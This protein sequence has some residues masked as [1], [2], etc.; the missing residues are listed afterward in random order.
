MWIKSM[1][2]KRG[3]AFEECSHPD[4][5]TAQQLASAEHISGHRVAKVVVVLADEHLVELVLPA[6]RHVD[7]KMVRQVLGVEEVRLASESEME[8]FF[9]GCEVGA[10][11]PLHHWSGVPVLM[12]AAMK[13][14]GIIIFQAGT[15]REAVRLNFADWFEIVQPRVAQFTT[16]GSRREPVGV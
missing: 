6:T 11:P 4:V 14:E 1:L 9:P 2:Q 16:P 3:V 12:D 10:V 5:Y 13:V 15:H 7:L 8:K